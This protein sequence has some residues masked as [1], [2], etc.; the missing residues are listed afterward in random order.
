MDPLPTIVLKLQELE[1]KLDLMNDV[2]NDLKKAPSES[3]DTEHWISEDQLARENFQKVLLLPL[4]KNDLKK[5]IV[6]YSTNNNATK[7]STCYSGR[8][9]H[10]GT[11]RG[12][13][14]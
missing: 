10:Y 14:F 5:Q 2:L 4:E 3:D 11:R 12:R 13:Q 6:H 8:R 1:K 9:H 7:C